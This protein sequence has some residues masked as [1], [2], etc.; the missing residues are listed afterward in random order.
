M[1]G[2]TVYS[3]HGFN[4]DDRG[5]ATTD[6]LAA[7][8]RKHGLTVLEIDR[9]HEG[10]IAAR[11]RDDDVVDRVCAALEQQTLHDMDRTVLIGHS[12]GCN[13]AHQICRARGSFA[14]RLVYL[15]NPALRR[16]ALFPRGTHVV[17]YYS[18]NDRTVTMSLWLR[19]L[20]WNWFAEHPWGEAGRKG[21]KWTNPARVNVNLET[22]HPAVK[23][24][25]H[26]TVFQNPTLLKVVQR[27]ILARMKPHP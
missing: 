12:H 15:I 13:I 26:S 3:L 11:L 6:R 19:L 5:A 21:L 10:L 18:A 7:E 14:P 23:V 9:E 24:V 20:P 1:T 25:K 2:F 17:C 8:L 16:T 4:V 22:M 27:D